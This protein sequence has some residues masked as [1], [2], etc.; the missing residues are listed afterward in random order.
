MSCHSLLQGIFPTQGLNQCVNYKAGCVCARSLQSC[1]TLCN[2][3]DGSPSASSVHGTPQARTLEWAAISLSGDLPDPGMEP[4]SL[5]LLPWQADSLPLAS[6]SLR[7]KCHE[8]W[9]Y[10][11][12]SSKQWRRAGLQD[13][14]GWGKVGRELRGDADLTGAPSAASPSTFWT[15]T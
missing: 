12:R 2:P 8:M 7:K 6:L 4:A 3:M 9:A 11:Q 14:T 13:Q 10:P 1:P 15:D 5:C